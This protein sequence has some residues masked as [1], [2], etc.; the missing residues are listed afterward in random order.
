MG[1][2]FIKSVIAGLPSIVELIRKNHP[3]IVEKI[4]AKDVSI[5]EI[6][7]DLEKAIMVH[8]TKE[9]VKVYIEGSKW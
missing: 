1:K 2:E 8:V 5:E 4:K 3:E 9:G 6:V 7:S